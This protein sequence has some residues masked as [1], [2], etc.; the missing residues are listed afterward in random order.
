MPLNILCSVQL[1]NLSGALQYPNTKF[2]KQKSFNKRASGINVE[3]T[4]VHKVV[5]DII[6]RM[7]EYDNPFM[8]ESEGKHSEV[9]KD[10]ADAKE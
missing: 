4:Q 6:A 1:S 9:E 5:C 3:E 8:K 7:K 10:G 2:K